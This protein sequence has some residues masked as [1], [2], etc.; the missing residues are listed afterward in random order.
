MTT[1][2]D[3]VVGFANAIHNV[4]STLAALKSPKLKYDARFKT[5]L[6]IASNPDSTTSPASIN[7]G[8]YLVSIQQFGY[9]YE[10]GR[11]K[12]LKAGLASTAKQIDTDIAQ[13]K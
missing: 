5:F 7:G 2:T 8:T 1:D 9:D 13:A 4:P 12:D 3:A 6:D 10:S 11:T